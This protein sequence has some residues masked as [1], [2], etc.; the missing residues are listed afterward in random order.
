[1][2]SQLQPVSDSSAWTA[3]DFPV[4]RSWAR[5]LG[6]TAL[7][8]LDAAM[9]RAVATGTPF[10]EIRREDCPLPTF[11]PALAGALED[12][13]TGAGF[14][15]FTG[16]PFARYSYDE[17]LLCYAIVSAHLGVIVEQTHKGD[18]KIDVTDKGLPYDHKTR[19]YS[20]NKLLPFHTDGADIVGLLSLGKAAEGGLSILVSAASVYNAILAE[21]PDLLAVLQ[22]GFHHHRRGEHEAGEAAVSAERIPVFA[23]HVG[24]LH[25]C[26]NRNPVEWAVKEGVV[27]TDLEHEALDYFDAVAA[28][29][30][31][32]IRMELEPGDIQYVN[33]YA[34]LHSRTEYRDDGAHKRHLVRMWVNAHDTRRAG[35]TI[36]LLYAPHVARQRLAAD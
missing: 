6:E 9:R 4:R 30:E 2:A 17:A 27:L 15:L 19:G 8:D 22:R 14:A 23:F 32:Q 25:C 5:P 21:R 16:F 33:N 31:M 10:H 24:I 20:S 3:A 26:Y 12:L 18:R 36:Q 7:A 13:E 34:V 1:M 28:R 29:P 35:P 11:G